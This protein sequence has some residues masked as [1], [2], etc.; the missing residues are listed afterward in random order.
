MNRALLITLWLLCSL[1]M[2]LGQESHSPQTTER[3]RPCALHPVNGRMCVNEE[4]LRGLL[5]R[6]V[7]PKLPEGANENGEVVLH[8]MIPA[9][10]GN[11]TNISPV[12]GDT[13]L[14]RSA[15]RAVR[16]WVFTAY[17]YKHGHVAIEGDLHIHFKTAQ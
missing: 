5:I 15:V 2:T 8:V 17:Q 16:D 6:Y 10:G 7:A 11:A 12:S 4:T 14:R 1:V 13:A 9:T 3:V